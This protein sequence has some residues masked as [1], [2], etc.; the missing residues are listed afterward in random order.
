M[1]LSRRETPV[2][3]VLGNIWL[4]T[5]RIAKRRVR[6]ITHTKIRRETITWPVFSSPISIY[7]F[8]VHRVDDSVTEESCEGGEDSA[9]PVEQQ[10]ENPEHTAAL[11]LESLNQAALHLRRAMVLYTHLDHHLSIEMPVN[12]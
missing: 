6:G 8:P 11:L 1:R 4:H 12:M 9:Q 3:P 7:F 5:Q 2:I 10:T